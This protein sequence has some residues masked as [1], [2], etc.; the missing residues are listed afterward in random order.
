MHSI[1]SFGIHI[2]IYIIF[3]LYREGI[4][5]NTFYTKISMPVHNGLIGSPMYS[6]SHI[7]FFFCFFPPSVSFVIAEQLS[8]PVMPIRRGLRGAEASK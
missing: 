4:E 1:L 6:L 2:Q 3:V 8:I 7:Y 5:Y